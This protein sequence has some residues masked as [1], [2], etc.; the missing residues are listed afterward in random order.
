MLILHEKYI[1]DEKG[2]KTAT[3]LPYAQWEKVLAI[4]EEYEDIRAYDKVKS[5][6]SHPVP[7]KEAIKKLK[8]RS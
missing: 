5:K 6:P 1:I 4:L 8:A 2:K 7:F 3:I